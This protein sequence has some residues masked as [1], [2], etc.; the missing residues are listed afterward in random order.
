ML[1]YVGK[2]KGVTYVSNCELIRLPSPE[3]G[4]AGERQIVKIILVHYHYQQPG[5]EDVVFEQ[6]RRA[7]AAA[8]TRSW[9][10]SRSNFEDGFLSRRQTAGA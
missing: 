3:G 9:S 6:E 8:G 7:L 5:G 10:S 1:D 2:R 4:S